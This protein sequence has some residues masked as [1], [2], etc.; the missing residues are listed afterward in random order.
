MTP[1][2][3]G[4]LTNVAI[5][6]DEFA[7]TPVYELLAAAAR[8]HLAI[9]HRFLHAILDDPERSIG[10][11]VRFAS[12]SREGDRVNLEEDLI[13]IARHLRPRELIPFLVDCV[14]RHGH[15]VPGRL[16]ETLCGFREA[17]V[18]PLLAL[19]RRCPRG[20]VPEVPFL[21]A[22]LGVRDPR[23]EQVL[24]EV[25]ETDPEE[26]QFCEQIYAELSKGTEQTEPEDIWSEYPES[27]D[28]P[29]EL[30]PEEECLE[31]L[32]STVAEHRR[33]AAAT[34][35]GKDCSAQTR[36]A[37]LCAARTDPDPS[38]RGLC[39]KALSPE[40]DDEALRRE[41]RARLND[42]ATPPAEKAGLVVALCDDP[43][44][45][46]RAH[47][48]ELL[49]HPETRAAALEAA[50][51]SLDPTFGS[52][53]RRHLDDADAAV[54]EQAVLGI[55]Y[56]QI[57]GELDRLKGMFEDPRLRPAALLAYTLACP[58]E[59]SP[60]GMEALLRQIDQI[61]GGLSPEETELVCDAL[62]QRLIMH[63]QQPLFTAG[64]SRA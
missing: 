32:R 63:G 6:P 19:Y 36:E 58:A 33:A 12:E 42:P 5:A 44:P 52:L 31:F 48:L 15:D 8:G 30:L 53:V 29:L 41:M 7:A 27:A 18:E 43:E 2:A 21:L 1:A 59:V 13:N 57:R 35:G 64:R 20:E 26:R 17:A 51:K 39:W 38:A 3:A 55:G 10:D 11:L 61:S 14:R 4:Q 9:D 46:V 34:L 37:L 56:L 24:R 23:I 16:A 25:G 54:R 50:W 45:G 60:A 22:A 49:E 28:P 40:A 62:D 47:I